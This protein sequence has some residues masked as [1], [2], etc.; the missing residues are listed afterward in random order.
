MKCSC[1]SPGFC[2]TFQKRISS[3][4]FQICQGE[5]LTPEVCEVYRQHWL[6]YKDHLAV[7]SNTNVPSYGPGT[8]VADILTT[9]GISAEQCGSCSGFK[10]LMNS[11]GT[12]G[13]QSHRELIIAHLKAAVNTTSFLEKLSIGL[14]VSLNT[15]FKIND[16][17]GCIVDEAIRRANET[18]NRNGNL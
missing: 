10:R 4:Q 6:L 17:I 14:S 12:H 2:E 3:Y 1:Q 9:A 7:S 15:W 13:C 16:P 18:N 8:E 5:V 11:W